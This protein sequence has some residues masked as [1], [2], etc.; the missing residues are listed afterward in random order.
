MKV[1]RVLDKKDML[2][3]ARVDKEIDKMQNY[4][5]NWQ[6]EEE[7]NLFTVMEKLERIN[8]LKVHDY[9]EAYDNE[10]IDNVREL[11]W[12]FEDTENIIVEMLQNEI[13]YIVLKKRVIV[14][15]NTKANYIG[16]EMWDTET[17]YRDLTIYIAPKSCDAHLFIGQLFTQIENLKKDGK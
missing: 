14:K 8:K 16:V 5:R 12:L 1:K 9:V 7:D 10:T 3:I 15:V 6:L 11:E 4:F 2:A 13:Y 17:P